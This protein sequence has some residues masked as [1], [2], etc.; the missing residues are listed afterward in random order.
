MVL[1]S[2]DTWDHLWETHQRVPAPDQLAAFCP[3]ALCSGLR[4][5]GGE[6]RGAAGPGVLDTQL[7]LIQQ[8]TGQPAPFQLAAQQP[9]Q[10]AAPRTE[11]AH[12]VLRLRCFSISP[13]TGLGFLG[14]APV[15]GSVTSSSSLGKCHSPQEIQTSWPSSFCQDS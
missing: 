11:G 12:W 7:V 1:H 13:C 10:P 2:Q 4:G 3:S 14:R 8:L 5:F 6:L 9:C 15:P